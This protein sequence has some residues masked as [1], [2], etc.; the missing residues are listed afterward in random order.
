MDHQP[1]SHCSYCGAAFPDNASWPRICAD[2]G[3]TSFRNPL[4]VAVVIVPIQLS[5]A[6]RGILAIRR[7]IPPRSGELALPGG[8]INYGETWQEAGAREVFEETGLRIDPEDI[9]EFRVRSAPDSTLI[10]FGLTTSRAEKDLPP[11]LPN[12]ESSERLVLAE[13][14]PMAFSLHSEIVKLI[15]EG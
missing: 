8:F 7:A 11:F 14:A 1:Y 12:I 10:I 2:C 5:P 4:P 3:N 15:L 6:E 13:P 9:V